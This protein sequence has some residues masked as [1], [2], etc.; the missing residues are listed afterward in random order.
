[1]VEQ[2]T[3]MLP[4]GTCEKWGTTT[5]DE[6]VAGGI[7]NLCLARP[8]GGFGK[9]T[10]GGGAGRGNGLRPGVVLWQS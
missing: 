1:M 5:Q 6:G 7:K 3:K 2:E 4:R 10:G 9:K 8:V